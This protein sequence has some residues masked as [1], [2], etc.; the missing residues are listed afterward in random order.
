MHT[1]SVIL[2]VPAVFHRLVYRNNA[3]LGKGVPRQH[4]FHEAWE[5]L[6]FLKLY[7]FDTMTRHSAFF[8]LFSP[9]PPPSKKFLASAIR[10]GNEPD[11]RISVAVSRKAEQM[12]QVDLGN[13]KRCPNLGAWIPRLAAIP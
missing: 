1:P 7:R 11:S 8:N 5:L 6:F 3:D 13:S 10:S 9:P 2:R 4:V 12:F